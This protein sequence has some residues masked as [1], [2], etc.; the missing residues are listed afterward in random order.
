[1]LG[2]PKNLEE[3]IHGVINSF[4]FDKGTFERRIN[5]GDNPNIY[6]ARYFQLDLCLKRLL[7]RSKPFLKETDESREE[8]LNREGYGTTTEPSWRKERD[9]MQR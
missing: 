5:E 7:E 4:K 3:A 9:R 6:L 1:M 2:D 8:R